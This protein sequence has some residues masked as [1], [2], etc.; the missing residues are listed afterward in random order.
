M[1]EN[2]K[3]LIRQALNSSSGSVGVLSPK[4]KAEVQESEEIMSSKFD[5]IKK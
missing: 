2:D 5:E 1:P 4:I 3:S